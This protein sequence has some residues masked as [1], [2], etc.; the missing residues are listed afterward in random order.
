MAQNSKE[1]CNKVMRDCGRRGSQAE[2]VTVLE[3]ASCASEQ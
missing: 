3:F 2:E 1:Q